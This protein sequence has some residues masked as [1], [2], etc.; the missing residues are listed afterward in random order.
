MVMELPY[1]LT[2]SELRAV[3]YPKKAGLFEPGTCPKRKPL[4]AAR[5]K[6][7]AEQAGMSYT[8]FSQLLNNAR[9]KIISAALKQLNLR[10]CESEDILEQRRLRSYSSRQVSLDIDSTPGELRVAATVQ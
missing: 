7:V 8:N 3:K 6:E 5:I 10:T 1:S 4:K 9:R 2:A